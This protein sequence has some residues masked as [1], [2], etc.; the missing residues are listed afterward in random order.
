MT[1]MPRRE[2]TYAVRAR[3]WSVVILLLVAYIVAVMDRQILSLLV[4]PV[5]AGLGITDTQLSLLQGFAFV[6]TFM[7]LGVFLDRGNRRNPYALVA[8]S[9]L[10]AVPTGLASV[11]IH[12]ITPNE[13]RGQIIAV[14]LLAAAVGLGAGPSAVAS[15]NAVLFGD[16]LSIGLALAVVTTT[17]AIA[18]TLLLS[19]AG[20]L[21]RA[22][23]SAIS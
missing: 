4:Q 9:L 12:Q 7:L 11:A 2:L 15:T 16:D 10:L 22:R 3:A 18:G 21:V 8:C 19:R 13:H 5:R 17:A 1:H 6:I 20:R 14:H 23:V